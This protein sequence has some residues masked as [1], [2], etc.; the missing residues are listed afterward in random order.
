MACCQAGQKLLHKFQHLPGRWTDS[1]GNENVKPA[2]PGGF[3]KG[4]YFQSVQRLLYKQ[5]RDCRIGEFSRTWVEINTCPVR[6]WKRFRPAAGN[7]HCNTAK[8]RQSK[9]RR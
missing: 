8:V 3:G 7:M 2:A 6:F 5:P 1:D 4:D 9:L